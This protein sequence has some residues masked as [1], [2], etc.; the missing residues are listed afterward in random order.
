M[1]ESRCVRYQEQRDEALHARDASDMIAQEARELAQRRTDQHR[2]LGLQCVALQDQFTELR[3]M[4]RATEQTTEVQGM[5]EM[6]VYARLSAEIN[7]VQLQNREMERA[8]FRELQEARSHEDSFRRCESHL[9]QRIYDLMATETELRNTE[10]SWMQMLDESESM[11]RLEA[12]IQSALANESA[13]YLEAETLVSR[14]RES[15]S[16]ASRLV[17]QLRME[18]SQER[19]KFGAAEMAASALPRQLAASEADAASFRREVS[20]QRA[21]PARRPSP[22]PAAPAPLLAP[23]GIPSS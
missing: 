18:V 1:L 5:Q 13:K 11:L 21:A 15:E 7:G 23:P 4:L 16:A 2:H 9:H 10:E 14:L 8:M 3:G 17:S 22:A 19:D 20:A 12:R 6:R